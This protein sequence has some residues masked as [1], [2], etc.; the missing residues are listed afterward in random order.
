[1]VTLQPVDPQY[2][3][4]EKWINPNSEYDVPLATQLADALGIPGDEFDLTSELV[5]KRVRVIAKGGKSK[6]D[7][8]DVVYVNGFLEPGPVWKANVV[9]AP[10]KAP[11][12]RTAHQKVK[13]DVAANGAADDDVPFLWLLPFV[14]C[15]AAGVIA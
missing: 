2:A 5:G 13:A 4:L 9:A 12:K 10:A 15:A 3:Q 6:K 1:M 11:P 8:S 14:L 7:G